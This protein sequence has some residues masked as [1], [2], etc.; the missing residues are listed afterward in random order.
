M[1]SGPVY[2]VA[3]HPPER[4][5]R[6][7]GVTVCAGCCCCCCCCL[8]AAGS[9]IGAAAASGKWYNWDKDQKEPS[10]APVYW[11]VFAV[12][13]MLAIAWAFLDSR[14]YTEK[15]VVVALLLPFG[16]LA[17]SV[18]SLIIISVQSGEDTRGARLRSLGRITAFSVVGGLLGT[19]AMIA[20][21]YMWP[22]LGL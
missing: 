14:Q 4:D 8:H 12:A 9:V 17:V 5:R 6:R 7:D 22:L 18:I 11:S 21:A 16:Q 3:A 20:A 10:A 13:A 15:L 1:A 19:V 2:D